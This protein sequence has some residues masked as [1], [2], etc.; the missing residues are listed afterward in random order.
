MYIFSMTDQG[1]HLS[2]GAA[3]AKLG[4]DPNMVPIEA[5]EAILHGCCDALDPDDGHRFKIEREEVVY[6]RGNR[7]SAFQTMTLSERDQTGDYTPKMIIVTPP[8]TE[9]R[10]EVRVYTDPEKL[11]T[12]TNYAE[13]ADIFQPHPHFN[14]DSLGPDRVIALDGR[15][16]IREKRMPSGLQSALTEEVGKVM[17]KPVPRF[18]IGYEPAA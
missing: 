12:I 4:V 18:H 5:S 15:L 2:L 13:P 16:N 17:G 11:R 14:S 1:L 3:A 7:P 10:H 8:G 6:D 9:G